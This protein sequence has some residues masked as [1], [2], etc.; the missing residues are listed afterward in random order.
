LQPSATIGEGRL[1][2]SHVAIFLHSVEGGGAERISLNLAGGIAARG[3]RVDLVLVRRT[4]PYLEQLPAGVRVVDLGCR[5]HLTCLLP[6]ARYLRRER[7]GVLLSA[8]THTNLYAL[9]ARRLARSDVR[10]VIRV[11][12]TLTEELRVARGPVARVVRPA[13]A[14]MLYPSADAIVAV[15]HGAGESLRRALGELGVPL[16]VIPN[17]VVLPSL[18]EQASQPAIH[19]WFREG[20]APVLLAVGRLVPQKDFVTLIRAFE[21][22]LRQNPVRLLILGEGNERAR[23]ESLIAESGLEHDVQLPGF[24]GN[25][26]AYMA[27]ARGV[28]LSSRYEGAPSVLVEALALGTPVAS[29]DCPSGPREILEGGRWGRLIKVGDVSALAAAMTEILQ[30]S[31]YPVP[32][33]EDLARYHLDHA[34]DRYLA[35]LGIGDR[36]GVPT[37]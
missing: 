4:G 3:L 10:V 18:Y 24:V 23:L 35:V 11:N 14:R 37:A 32:R 15:S 20:S 2:I 9:A 33:S 31:P 8:L 28:I 1:S 19:P 21:L 29:T 22:V 30:G 25:P 13:M 5:R 26:Y 17:P 36:T 27:A 6:L 7:P 34:V 12:N 16:H